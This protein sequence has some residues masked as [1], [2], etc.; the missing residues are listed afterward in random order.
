MTRYAPKSHTIN[1]ILFGAAL[2]G[3]LGLVGGD[4]V[5][6]VAPASAA[7]EATSPATGKKGGTD[8]PGLRRMVEQAHDALKKGDVKTAIIY[9]K[10][11]V[12]VAP[13]NGQVRAELGYLL[14]RTG[15][16]VSAER[17]LR[18]AR[19]DG[20]PDEAVLPSLFQA[21][22]TRGKAADIL[23]QFPD[24][25]ASDKSTRAADILRA[26][27]IALEKTGKTTEA[28]NAMDRAL[29]IRRDA[30]SLLTRATL[31]QEQGDLET[32]NRITDEAL[33]MAPTD[34]GSL[35]M[36]ISLLQ[37]AGKNKEALEV[38]DRLVRYYP[39]TPAPKVARIGVLFKL[40]DDKRAESDIHAILAKQPGLP[41]GVYYQAI[42]KARAKDMKTA[43][44]LAQSLPPEFVS[45]Q[46]AIGVAIAQIALDNGNDET[47]GSILANTV[48]RF[49]QDP[50]ARIRLGALRLRQKAP[51]QALT[52]LKPLQNSKDARAM[53]LLGQ[54]YAQSRQYGEATEYFERA[55][56]AGL[57][58]DV[59][60]T[61]LALTELKTGQ[62]DRAISQLSELN[63]QNPNNPETAGPL[64]AALI[65]S[66][67][68]DDAL[69]VANNLVKASPKKP[70]PYLYR[71]QVLMY[72]GDL[73]G[74]AA[75]FSDGLKV[76]PKF[77]PARYYRAQ[78]LAAQGETAEA[79]KELDRVLA[80]DPKNAL[81]LIRKAQLA[82]Q[83]GREETVVPSLK[84]AIEAAPRDPTPSMVL[85]T[86]YLSQKDYKQAEGYANSA[87]KISPNSEE[88][89]ALLGQIQFARGSHDQASATFRRLV[90]IMPQS[91][92][93]QILLGNAL[94][95]T[96][97][98]GGALSAFSRAV[99]LDPTS[100]Q[101]RNALIDFSLKSGQSD[102]ALN[103]T[104][105][106]A[107]SYPGATADILMA[108]TLS[109]MKKYKE[110]Q[111]TLAKGYETHPTAELAIAYARMAQ[112]TGD[113]KKALSILSG[114]VGKN[115]SDIDGRREYGSLLLTSGDDA[116]AL[117]QFEAVLKQQ[118]YDVVALNN[119]GWLI[120]K[121]DPK[122]AMQL[123][124]LAA[125]IQPQS[126][127]IL[128]TLGWLK[129]QAN[130]KKGA[131]ALLERAHRLDSNDPEIAYHYV[132][133]LDAA[134]K[135]NEAKTLL[136]KLLDSGA[137]FDSRD[138]ASRL[139]AEWK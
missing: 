97:N 55:T 54:A 87:L 58:N 103:V 124:G 49:P 101:A 46:P 89:V 135:R 108:S 90:N 60:K 56:Q 57:S 8:A 112:M 52:I 133:T 94:V 114:W 77:V 1:R 78:V 9:L 109:K 119:V 22:L 26:R 20:A 72:R 36:K 4:L 16:A 2:V 139:A 82:I 23:E 120:Q 118:P 19:A 134:G 110:A 86:Y 117:Q 83:D 21:M 25:S 38:A 64:I 128:D 111:E 74:A 11:A 100:I 18:Q 126:A 136:K 6:G 105:E 122:R 121:K 24:P 69:K 67:R 15:D 12:T 51:E 115:P 7:Y 102:R 131:I 81:A 127:A 28:N 53:A 138:Q 79:G 92:G 3:V 59:I 10:N 17:E 13:K 62:S 33:K 45:S 40:G 48:T 123:V 61:Q 31:A 106:Y 132:V 42:L 75:A 84:K 39:D 29:A 107:K 91:S 43:W 27:A 93:A 14:L 73:K 47:A 129:W 80:Q 35:M 98:Q 63:A 71:G 70:L 65:Q 104:K 113:Q 88:G 116:G 66:R 44:K 41:I 96:K 68:F 34:A 76:D 125:K 95:A 137:K 50:E 32:A 85:A 5:H 130:D 99:E 30:P 37:T